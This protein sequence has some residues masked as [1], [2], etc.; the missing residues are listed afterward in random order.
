MTWHV[1]TLA[2]PEGHCETYV[3]VREMRINVALIWALVAT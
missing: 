2:C 1:C 3:A